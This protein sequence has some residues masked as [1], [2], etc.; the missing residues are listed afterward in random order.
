MKFRLYFRLLNPVLL[1]L[2][3]SSTA[4]GEVRLPHVLASRM[5]LQRDAPVRIWGW[6]EAGEKITVTLGDAAQQVNANSE[7]SWQVELP[8]QAADGEKRIIRVVGSN[9]VELTDL[10]VGD[11]W[12]GSGQSNMAW[13]LKSTHGADSAIAAADH[14]EVRLFHIPK[15]KA[16]APTDDVDAEWKICEPAT[17]PDFSA[18]LYYFG[19]KL[20]QQT[21]VPIGLIN[22]SWGGSAIE[23]WTI[24]ESGSGEMYN[25]MVAPI[26]NLSVRGA[27]WYQGETNVIQKN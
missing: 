6:A 1:L 24:T 13:Q 17:I 19:L 11:V 16:A 23:P 26:V 10:L 20:H 27:I 3:I 9:T 25:G 14:P 12:I 21:K 7:G 8:A 4:V 18:V 15:V 22:T 2:F 5:V